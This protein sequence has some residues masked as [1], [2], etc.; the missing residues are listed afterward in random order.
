MLYKGYYHTFLHEKMNLVCA[1]RYLDLFRFCNKPYFWSK[2][3][4]GCYNAR[5]FSGVIPKTVRF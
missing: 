1:A 3:S 2:G 5:H 4:C